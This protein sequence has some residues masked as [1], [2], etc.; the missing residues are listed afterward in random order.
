MRGCESS[1]SHWRNDK[2]WGCVWI[3]RVMIHG[4]VGGWRKEH[5]EEFQMF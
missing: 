4:V 2:N 3:F 5:N 1:H